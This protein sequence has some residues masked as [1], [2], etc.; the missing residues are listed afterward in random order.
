M[1][2]GCGWGPCLVSTALAACQR[3]ITHVSL[4]GVEASRS[5]IEKLRTHFR[6]NRLDADGHTIINAAIDDHDA[7]PAPEHVD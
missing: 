4:A 1:E 6:D 2:L 3:D 7:S 5:E